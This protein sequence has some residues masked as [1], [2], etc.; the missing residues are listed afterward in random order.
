MNKKVRQSVLFYRLQTQLST[1]LSLPLNT[2]VV[3]NFEHSNDACLS[4]QSQT[5][6]NCGFHVVDSGLQVRDS[7]YSLLVKLGFWIP[8]VSGSSDSLS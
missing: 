6:L 7:G 3:L 4:N 1:Q 2:C 8:V 5:V